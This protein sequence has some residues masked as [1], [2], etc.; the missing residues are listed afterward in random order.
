MTET[1]VIRERFD[2]N[3]QESNVSPTKFIKLFCQ[4]L[5]LT[6]E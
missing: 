3:L 2:W 6:Q 1:I 4:K 5:N